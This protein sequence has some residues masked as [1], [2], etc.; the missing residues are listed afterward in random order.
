MI[1]NE[2]DFQEKNIR[3]KQDKKLSKHFDI[4]IN[5][6]K[7]KILN[8][9]FKVENIGVR[10]GDYIQLISKF[11]IQT[12]DRE[13]VKIIIIEG[14]NKIEIH[15]DWAYASWNV[16]NHCVAYWINNMIKK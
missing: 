5:D 9:L 3:Q 15:G 1:E 4:F 12:S 2:D 6:E 13:N 16:G 10:K 7:V 14:E 8:Y 11:N